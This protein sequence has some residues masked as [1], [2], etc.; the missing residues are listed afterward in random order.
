LAKPAGETGKEQ[1]VAKLGNYVEFEFAVRYAHDA[2]E[3]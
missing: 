3:L 1:T 2:F